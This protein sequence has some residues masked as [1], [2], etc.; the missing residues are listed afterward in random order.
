MGRVFRWL[1]WGVVVLVVAGLAV[2]FL[3]PVSRFI[4]ELTLAVSQK[5]GQPVTIEDLRLHL[6]PT[7]RVIAN[8]ITVGKAEQVLIGELEIVPE[9]LPLLWGRRTI[10]VIRADKV[11]I[12]ETALAIPRGMPK[13]KPG[14][15]V[16]VRRV[17]LT[18][19]KLNH[20][21]VDLPQFDI[22]VHLK[23][24]LQ[25]SEARF[26]AR[27]GSFS[28]LVVPQ[29]KDTAEVRL[30]ARNWT[31]P[32]GTPLTFETLVAQGVLKGQQ[33]DLP[34]IEGLLYGG[35]VA[36]SARA[37]WG[38]QWQVSGKAKLSG[39]DLAPL[40]QAMGK[41]AKL[42]GRLKA[43]AAFS[44]R[45][46]SPADLREGLSLDGPFEVLGGV[47]QGVDLSK[48]GDLTGK[49]A[50]GDAT[51]F[52][53]LKGRL[54]LRGHNIKLSELCVRSPKV[55][56]GGD[57]QIAPDH[58][59][60]G[61]LDVSVAKTGGFVGVPVSLSGTTDDPSLSPTRGYMIGAAIGTVILPV[62]GTSIGS[63]LGSRL[64]GTSDCK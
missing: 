20:A 19:V 61:R 57:V 50:D 28:L 56:A 42:S 54:E 13:G 51:T 9:L 16:L 21:T 1:F 44:S 39:V 46:R 8:H 49:R 14:E 18:Q 47:Y 12:D 23:G 30:S 27:D 26:E 40:Q 38:K 34:K 41:P 37:D 31:L 4:P 35:Q 17:F 15:P 45:A 29:G 53:E 36:G 25:V 48:A 22:D 62:I 33:L 64:E 32:A 55:V 60:S 10:R 7:P 11:A 6:L 5:L 59:L 24:G 63:S 52:E 58:K 43:D 2:P 3:V